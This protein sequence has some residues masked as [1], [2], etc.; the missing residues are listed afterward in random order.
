ME[1]DIGM[2]YGDG[3][4]ETPSFK[5]SGLS[6]FEY[7]AGLGAGFEWKYSMGN[8]VFCLEFTQQKHISLADFVVITVYFKTNDSRMG[9]RLS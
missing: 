1:D 6:R 3:Y 8:R 4:S 9:C 5:E 2:R 7:G